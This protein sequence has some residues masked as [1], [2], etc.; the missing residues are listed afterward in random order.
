MFDKDRE[1]T[2]LVDL[3]KRLVEDPKKIQ[4]EIL[5]DWMAKVINR[6]LAE[7]YKSVEPREM[8]SN[9]TIHYN[10]WK[11]IQVVN[12]LND[13]GFE[14]LLVEEK[15]PDRIDSFVVIAE[16]KNNYFK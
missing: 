10:V 1:L 8:L 2:E 16:K 5:E 7:H 6:N 12:L 15:V 13:L 3:K 11:P 9:G 14:V 4:E